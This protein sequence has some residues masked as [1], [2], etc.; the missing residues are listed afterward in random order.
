MEY[1][2]EHKDV[3]FH[4]SN[5]EGVGELVP[6]QANCLSKEFGNLNAVYATKDSIISMFHSIRDK[7]KFSGVGRAGVTERVNK[8]TGE[9]IKVYHLGVEKTKGI[10]PWSSGSVVILDVE[11]FKQ[12]HDDNGRFIDEYASLNPVLPLTRL[13]IRPEEFPLLD[14]VEDLSAPR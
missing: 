7:S 2:A 8:E 12:G 9:T 14:Q 13:R 4:G 6:M 11:N 5:W 3:V 1:V 10:E